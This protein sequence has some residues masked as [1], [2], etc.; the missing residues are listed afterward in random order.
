MH[1]MLLNMSQIGMLHY[2][3]RAGRTLGDL[4]VMALFVCVLDCMF[5]ECF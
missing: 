3:I 4:R 2:G 1:I 5:E